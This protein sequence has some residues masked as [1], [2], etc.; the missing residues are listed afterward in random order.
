MGEKKNANCEKSLKKQFRK[1]FVFVNPSKKTIINPKGNET[2]TGQ[3]F[4]PKT[5]R[6]KS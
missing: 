1:R 6:K 2:E 5:A 3:N 4:R